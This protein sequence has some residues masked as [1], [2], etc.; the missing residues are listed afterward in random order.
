MAGETEI[1]LSACGILAHIALF[2]SD[3]ELWKHALGYIDSCKTDSVPILRAKRVLELSL[4]TAFESTEPCFYILP[5]TDPCVGELYLGGCVCGA[6][7]NILQELVK[8]NNEE[9]MR[10]LSVV[11]ADTEAYSDV[12]RLYAY[13][14]YSVL[15]IA[16]RERL[17]NTMEKVFSLCHKGQ[18][19]SPLAETFFP[20]SSHIEKKDYPNHRALIDSIV[21]ENSAYLGGIRDIGTAMGYIS[22]IYDLT[23]KEYAV[24]RFSA[25]GMKGP[26]IAEKMGIS[27][28]TVK[29][30]LSIYTTSLA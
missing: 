2:Q 3:I 20:V 5:S 16:D 14:V 21:Q 27:V 17:Q 30:T 29:N 13:M 28:N 23:G 7:P 8:G 10:K 9:A 25:D 11:I 26:E 6:I 24:A 1:S 19:Y 22:D 12:L 4:M 18:I 15:T